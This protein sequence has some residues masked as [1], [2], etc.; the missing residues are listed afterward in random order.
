MPKIC[1][2]ILG[3]VDFC[4]HTHDFSSFQACVGTAQHLVKN[5]RQV[6]LQLD[7]DYTASSSAYR[8]GSSSPV[9]QEDVDE[10]EFPLCGLPCSGDEKHL[11]YT[12]YDLLMQAD[13][14]NL[15]ESCAPDT[16][17]NKV[18]HENAVLLHSDNDPMLSCTG[19]GRESGCPMSLFMMWA[20]LEATENDIQAVNSAIEAKLLE[21]AATGNTPT[22]APLF[23]GNYMTVVDESEDTSHSS[24]DDSGDSSDDSG[25]AGTSADQCGD[26][27][28]MSVDE[29]RDASVMSVDESRDASVTSVDESRDAT[30]DKAGQYRQK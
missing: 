23:D 2:S 19:S 5:Y 6:L 9:Q 22:T 15:S 17:S 4:S 20:T 8:D 12:D 7:H 27:S 14:D 10:C 13:H 26:V 29:S 25:I 30:V 28:V 1:Y 11:E 16:P 3:N 24:M 21:S 18:Q